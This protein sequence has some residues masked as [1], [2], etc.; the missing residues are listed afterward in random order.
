ML[1][2]FFGAIGLSVILLI[3]IIG[4]LYGMDDAPSFYVWVKEQWHLGMEMHEERKAERAFIKVNPL[5][6][7]CKTNKIFK[8]STHMWT[9]TEEPIALCDECYERALHEF[10]RM[11]EK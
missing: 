4:A 9:K 7:K 10:Y 2:V 6:E 3:F 5:C 1:Y 8:K 11:E